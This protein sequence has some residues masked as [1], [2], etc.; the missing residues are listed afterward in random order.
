MMYN[1]RDK[2]GAHIYAGL[3]IAVHSIAFT[4]YLLCVTQE[5]PAQFFSTSCKKKLASSAPNIST[6][7]NST[8]VI[9]KQRM[10]ILFPLFRELAVCIINTYASM[11]VSELVKEIIDGAIIVFYLLDLLVKA[12]AICVLVIETV[13]ALRPHWGSRPRFSDARERFA[14][15]SSVCGNYCLASFWLMFFMCVWAFSLVMYDCSGR[16]FE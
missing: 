14:G 6:S 2:V 3:L 11:N 5:A 13:F 1:G 15:I 7:I 9:L 16:I 12:L 8:G 4:I 10:S